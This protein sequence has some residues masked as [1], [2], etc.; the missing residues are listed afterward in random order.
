MQKERKQ[1]E[2][3][4]Q[5]YQQGLVTEEE[6][7]LIARWLIHLD[8]IG[9]LSHEQL[10]ARQEL[11]QSD[12]K[13]HFA[14][15]ESPSAKITRFPVWIRSVA[16][17]L[18]I[19][20]TIA[21]IFYFNNKSHPPTTNLATFQ[22]MTTGSGEMKTIT[23]TDGTRITLNNESRLKYPVTF[24]GATREV[25]LTGEAFF[26]VAHNPA[27]PFEV[28]TDELDVQVLGTSF[29]VKAYG[30]DKELS[31]SVATG[32]VG[33]LPVG[34]KDKTYMLLPGEELAYSRSTGKF[35][36]SKIDAVDISAWQ[37]GKF[38]FSNE[39]LENIT[40]QLERYYKVTF[41]FNNKSVLAK[42]ISLK[43]KNQSISTVMKAMSISGEFRY[44][45]E[46]NKI[47]VW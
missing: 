41:L 18:L 12:L 6:K 24:N 7:A 10:Q 26:E 16:A 5:K 11:S 20:S 34:A 37:K 9:Q 25:F 39:T 8:V 21:G 40:R 1:L 47:T 2:E 3:L 38:I 33:V 30:G 19:I 36:Q 23:L 28:H 13:N 27:K 42:Q 46:G 44:K 31:V 22:Q 32:K 17:C 45:I 14:P 4:F 35:S 29:N 15:K 43:V